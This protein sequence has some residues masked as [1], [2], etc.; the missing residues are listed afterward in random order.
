M[1]LQQRIPAESAQ[2][3]KNGLNPGATAAGVESRLRGAAAVCRC[4]YY[5]VVDSTNERLKEMAENG[6]AAGTVVL[7]DCQSRGKG[8][9]GREF[10]SPAGTG[11]YISVLL[12]PFRGPAPLITVAAAVAVSQAIEEVCSL[13]T[14]IKWVNDIFRGDKKVCGILAESSLYHE[15]EDLDYVVLG[16]GVNISP[17]PAGFPAELSGIAGYLYDLAP[18]W[19]VRSALTAEILNK[20]FAAYA[21]LEERAYMAEYRRRSNLLGRGVLCLEG[22]R[23][24]PAR[25]L[26]INDDG[27][28]IV[29]LEDGTRKALSSGEVRVRPLA[30]ANEILCD[31]KEVK[32]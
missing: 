16:V 2:D 13:E 19:D 1:R 7:A 28:L 27:E 29:S 9:D 32:P 4:H 5:Q 8:R 14:R 3:E 31:I 26:A 25:A 18:A 10:F 12:R 22:G 6:A 15:T 17:P 23:S 30:A 11:A 21:N 24:Y 20:F